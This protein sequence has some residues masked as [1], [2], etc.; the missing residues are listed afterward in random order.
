M[1]PK[2]LF[3]DDS[4]KASL[5]FIR[6]LR[7]SGYEVDYFSDPTTAFKNIIFQNYKLAILDCLLPKE[8][9]FK[10]AERIQKETKQFIPIIFISGVYSKE[11]FEMYKGKSYAVGFLRKPFSN[12]DLI[13]YIEKSEHKIKNKNNS[14]AD[15]TDQDLT[16]LGFNKKELI[17]ESLFLEVL[18]TSGPKKINGFEIFFIFH[19][20]QK[21][22]ISGYLEFSNS[23][24]ESVGGAS[25]K[26][27]LFYKMNL[28]KNEKS[29]FLA[30]AISKSLIKGQILKENPEVFA[31]D[32]GLIGQRLVEANMLSPHAIGIIYR[33]QFLIR[34]SQIF[35]N[36]EIF[37]KFYKRETQKDYHKMLATLPEFK[38]K[39]ESMINF[40]FLKNIALPKFKVEWLKSFFSS[41][42]N[43]NLT[44]GVDWNL[45]ERYKSLEF[46]K[47]TYEK[48]EKTKLP[49][50]LN[51]FLEK[52]KN[53]E[54]FLLGIYGLLSVGIIGLEESTFDDHEREYE[55]LTHIYNSIKHKK[56]HEIF[57]LKERASLDQVNMS[58]K[59]L[60]QSFH[61]DKA[62]SKSP[63]KILDLY[64]NIFNVINESYRTIKVSSKDGR[65]YD[66]RQEIIKLKQILESE[67]LMNECKSLLKKTRFEE[68][69]ESLEKIGKSKS[70]P[71]DYMIYLVWAKLKLCLANPKKYPHF[72]RSIYDDLAKIPYEERHNAYYLYVQGLMG[73][74]ERD[75]DKALINFE[76]ASVLQP[77]FQEAEIEIDKIC[78][79]KEEKSFTIKALLDE[80]LGT[81]VKKV[82]TNKKLG[83]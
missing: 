66:K 32:I 13:H 1:K 9:G 64:K 82:L 67:T 19:K 56:A 18:N 75:K 22:G 15:N 34:F 21:L 50:S 58:Y 10:L 30:I 59:Q 40:Y 4:K 46:L 38:E 54:N 17:T 20:C 8:S 23:Q 33:E 36:K 14:N 28:E 60:S 52:N 80:D 37:V 11:N 62:P 78:G 26:D 68:A 57:G 63:K 3:I 6:F 47:D 7:E 71:N 41:K 39:Y 77:D 74:L 12:N 25:L 53:S 24:G 61:P 79:R 44:K 31:Q 29:R 69:L 45:F 70:P 43:Y 83:S 65:I 48:L 55:R 5:P 76:K 51:D 35:E 2:I 81:F 16:A 49:L 73:L 42:I 72:I 27:G